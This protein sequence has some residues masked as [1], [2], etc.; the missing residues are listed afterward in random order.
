MTEDKRWPRLGFYVCH[1]GGNI[2]DYVDVVKVRDALAEEPGVVVAR[3]VMFACS[4]S[5]QNEMIADIKNLKLDRIVVASCTPRLHEITF[6]NVADRGGLNRYT[7]Y[8]ANIREQTSWAHRDDKEGA[9]V[10]AI[11]HSRAAVAYAR[12]SEPLESI[13]APVTPSVL[14]V[15]GGIAGIRAAIDLADAG[16]AVHLIEREPFLGGRT[17][18]LTNS[19]PQDS[20]GSEVAARLIAEARKRDGIAIYTNAELV[21]LDGYIGNFEARVKLNPRYFKSSQAKTSLPE[22]LGGEAPSKFDYG[23]SKEGPVLMPPFSGAYPELPSLNMEAC[24]EDCARSISQAYGDAVDLHQKS[25]SLTIR[26]GAVI[27]A[28]GFDPYEPKEG[29]FG[30]RTHPKVVTLQQL[31]RLVELKMLK[32]VHNIAFI[33]CV[34]SRQVKTGDEDVNE[35]CSRYCCNAAMSISLV[36]LRMREE[37]GGDLRLYHLYRDIRTYGRNEVL[38]E[39]ALKK[40]VVFIKYSEEDPPAVSA[41]G[42]RLTVTVKDLLTVLDDKLEIP[43]DMVVL[44]TGMVPKQSNDALPQ[45]LRVPKGADRFLLEVHPKLKPVETAMAGVFIAGTCQGP[46]DVRETLASAQAASSKAAGIALMT[47]LE[48]DPFVAS[49]D[50][51]MCNLTKAC[52]AECEYGAIEFKEFPGLG[53]KA[54]VNGARCKGCGACVAVCPTGAIQLKGLSNEQ[55]KAQIEALGRKVEI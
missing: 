7:Y 37:L 14:V 23:L 40:E 26:A 24:S 44:V 15:G 5:S 52:A 6:R 4:D 2:S 20:K 32:D 13:K 16:I 28:A 35:Y 31:H 45:I 43:V 21:G 46:K 49:V 27:A 54:W 10:K 9:T 38:Y 18:Q 11:R 8:H 22:Q 51:K 47:Q 50:P 3:D 17:A 34:G 48:L 33:Y 12:L 42:G 1:C 29:E 36:L 19:Y 55:L 39:E 53:E 25:E 41:A 30:Y